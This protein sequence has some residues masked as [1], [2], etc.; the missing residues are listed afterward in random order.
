[1]PNLVNGRETASNRFT[2]MVTKNETVATLDALIAKAEARLALLP[3]YIELMA[4][5][6]ARA[7]IMA[8]SHRKTET[9][10]DDQ[11][12]ETILMV[13]TGNFSN[14]RPGQLEATAQVLTQAGHPLPTPQLVERA[15]KLG[16]KIGGKNPRTNLGSTLSRSDDF[17][18]VRW[19]GEPAW[20][21]KNK[22]VP[23]ELDS[24]LQ[25]AE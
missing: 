5:K 25:A 8:A 18:S 21:F 3:D 24:L 23:Q 15:V 9:L 20:W 17:R 7:E 10:V 4:L 16:A 14:R 12:G 2:T 19:R 11:T 1:M 6:K 13:P 22:P